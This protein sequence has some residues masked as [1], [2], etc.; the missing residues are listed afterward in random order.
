MN[1]LTPSAVDSS[2]ITPFV[3]ITHAG[4]TCGLEITLTDY[5]EALAGWT[6][7]IQAGLDGFFH[8]QVSP[9]LDEVEIFSPFRI[10]L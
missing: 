8:E 9:F 3:P 2:T 4:I 1:A 10:A 5:E 6:K 7:W